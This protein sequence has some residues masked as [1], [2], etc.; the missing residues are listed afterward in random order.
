MK[1][2]PVWPPMRLEWDVGEREETRMTPGLWPGHLA[3]GIASV[4]MG[5]L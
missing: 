3:G 5:R 4:E 2:E 1:V